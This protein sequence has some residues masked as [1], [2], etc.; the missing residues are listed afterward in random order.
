LILVEKTWKKLW[1]RLNRPMSVR[2]VLG[3][4]TRSHSTKNTPVQNLDLLSPIIV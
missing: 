3:K 4:R 1:L 2:W